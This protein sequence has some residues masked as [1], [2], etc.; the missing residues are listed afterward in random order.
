MSESRRPPSPAVGL[1][2]RKRLE[3]LDRITHAGVRLFLEKGYDETTLDEIAA[4][5]D[6]SRRTFFYYFKSK[7]DILLSAQNSVGPM[8]AAA[9]EAASHRDQPIEAVREAVLSVCGSFS[10]EGMIE[11]GRLMR[12]SRTVLDRK[13]ASYISQEQAVFEALRKRWP[14]PEREDSLRLVAMLGIGVMRVASELLVQE[15]G[16]RPFLFLINMAFDRL[17]AEMLLSDWGTEA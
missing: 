11:M 16:R 14:M 2:E 15:N 1:R 4:A 17:A 3:T 13:Q 9:V 7:D 6:I 10:S 5:A 8:L 12:S